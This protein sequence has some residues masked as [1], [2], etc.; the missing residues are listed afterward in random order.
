METPSSGAEAGEQR[1]SLFRVVRPSERAHRRD[2]RRPGCP[3]VARCMAVPAVN[4]EAR[5][6]CRTARRE[7]SAME[8]GASNVTT[9][10]TRIVFMIATPR[11][12]STPTP[13]QLTPPRKPGNSIV[14]RRLGGV[15]IPSERSERMRRSHHSRSNRVN[16]HASLLRNPC[17]TTGEIVENGCVSAASSPATSL[18]GT[19]RSCVGNTGTPVSR[20]STKT[21]PVLDACTTTAVARPLCITVVSAGCAAAS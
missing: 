9:V 2:R 3:R 4:E 18:R 1:R 20:S 15:N 8:S 13:P 14:P 17:G 11:G 19:A 21:S 7:S 10:A 5:G 12:R 6:G 16:P